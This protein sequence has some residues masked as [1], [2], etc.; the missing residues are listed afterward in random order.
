MHY[1]IGITCALTQDIYCV[2]NSRVSG[3]CSHAILRTHII[4]MMS[5]N[6]VRWI[7]YRQGQ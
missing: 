6:C 3:Q 7:V 1:Q 5:R 2:M 4:N